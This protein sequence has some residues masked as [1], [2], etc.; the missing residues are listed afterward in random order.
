MEGVVRS[1]DRVLTV[2]AVL[3]GVMAVSNFWKPIAQRMAPESTAGFVFLGTRLHGAANAV[4]GPLF[5]VILAAYAYGAWTR[6][7]WV[8]P[9]AV[10]YALYV[11]AN[12]LLYLARAP[13]EGRPPMLGMMVYA[14]VAIGVSGGG[15]LYLWSRRDRLR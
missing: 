3:M 15:A 6:R 11:I 4:V 8:A 5:G 13:A 7:R 12:L 2:L 14:V 10:A 9:L 1:R